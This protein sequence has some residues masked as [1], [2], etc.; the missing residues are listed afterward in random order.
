MSIKGILGLLKKAKSSVDE[1]YGAPKPAQTETAESLA[2]DPDPITK[3]NLPALSKQEQGLTTI[4]PGG[5]AEAENYRLTNL[6]KK[7]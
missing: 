1:F 5:R 3:T 7:L 2:K 4:S 6:Y